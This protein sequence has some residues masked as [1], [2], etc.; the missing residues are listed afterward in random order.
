MKVFILFVFIF[1]STLS[2]DENVLYS[3]DF[4]KLQGKDALS[5]LRKLGFEF[6]LDAESLNFK[7]TQ[8]GLEFH[9][10]ENVAGLFGLR[11]KKPLENVHS[12]T[13]EWGVERFPQGSD[14]E[15]KNNRLAI[16]AIFLFGK[17][18][19][20]SGLPIFAPAAPYFF[21]PFIGEKE[22]VDKKYFGRLYKEGGRYYC[23]S[24]KLGLVVTHFDIAKRFKKEF[25]KAPPPLVAFA[26]QMNTKD[27]SGGAEAFIKKLTFYK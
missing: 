22:Q 18:K 7:L 25:Q 1:L 16:G 14:W 5:T 10:K 12:A 3:F 15:K 4:T 2:A 17:E 20:P 23:V 11:L 9:T 6:L 19:F 21:G 13:I 24:N 26:F 8:K 27:T